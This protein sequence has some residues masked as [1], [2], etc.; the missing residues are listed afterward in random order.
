MH[1]KKQI[2]CYNA[3]TVGGKY[4]KEEDIMEITW[5]DISGLFLSL[6]PEYQE[7]FISY[8][9]SMQDTADNSVPRPYG[10]QTG[11]QNNA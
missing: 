6:E 11:C 5:D 8:L 7:K 10:C 2:L 4:S 9:R 1:G 3:V